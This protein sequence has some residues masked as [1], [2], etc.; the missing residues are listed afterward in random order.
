MTGRAEVGISIPPGM[1]NFELTGD[2][3]SQCTSAMIP[4]GGIN[5]ISALLHTH[6]L[7]RKLSTQ[8][9]RNGTELEPLLK[10]D[11]YDFN[12]QEFI[13]FDTPR[14]LH[15]GLLQSVKLK[16]TCFD[17]RQNSDTLRL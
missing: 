5:V 4:P 9:I 6:L 14:V 13:I 11:H 7:G 1:K 17:R 16:L 10:I 12:F 8:I 15:P 2:C 3:T